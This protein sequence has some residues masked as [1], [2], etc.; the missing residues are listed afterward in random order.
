MLL[1]NALFSWLVSNTGLLLLLFY[2]ELL[3]FLNPTALLKA[4]EAPYFLASW[5]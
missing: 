4:D 5:F 2:A 1:E 3:K